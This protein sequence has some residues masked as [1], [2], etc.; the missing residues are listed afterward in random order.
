MQSI[1][2]RRGAD[3]IRELGSKSELL[4]IRAQNPNIIGG[5]SAKSVQIIQADA[6]RS[7]GLIRITPCELER[8]RRISSAEILMRYPI[9]RLTRKLDPYQFS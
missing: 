6:A 3:E 1:E 4:A 8:T 2:I 5:P 7:M 9:G